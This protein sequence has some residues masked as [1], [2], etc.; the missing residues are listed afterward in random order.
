MEIAIAIAALLIFAVVAFVPAPHVTPRY[1]YDE[2]GFP[3]ENGGTTHEVTADDFSDEELAA[4][5]DSSEGPV[6]V[7]QA[8]L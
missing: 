5:Q 8:A 1:T 7:P 6:R 4:A 2:N 3:T